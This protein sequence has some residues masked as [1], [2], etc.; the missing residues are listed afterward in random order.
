MLHI[1]QSPNDKFFN[2]IQQDP[3]RPNIPISSRLGTNR[4]IFCLV[5]ADEVQAITCVSYQQHVPFNEATL[6]ENNEP[7]VVVFYTIWSYTSGAGR[8]LL[9]DS[10]RHI[11]EHKPHIKRF[12]TL[13][14]K[15]EMAKSFHLRNGAS[16]YKENPDTVNYEY[17]LPTA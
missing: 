10:V 7:E 5:E 9:L 3:V 15:T 12:V 16:V 11:H 4:D 6:F 17:Q 8:R 14:P 13:S 1:I 2:Y